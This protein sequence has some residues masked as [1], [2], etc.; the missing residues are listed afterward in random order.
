MN[1]KARKDHLLL[2]KVDDEMVVYD[3]NRKTAHR[4]NGTAVRVWTSLDGHR[5]TSEIADDLDVDESIV[6]LSIDHLAEAHLVE[7]EEPF[8]VSRRQALRRVAIAAAAGFLLPVVTSIAA[9]TA[10]QA[11]SG[12][13]ATP[14]YRRRRRWYRRRRR[15]WRW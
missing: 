15:H 8:S 11:E 13:H 12:G 3:K 4:L 14:T 2:H 5:S 7:S 1:H 9:P 6:T 10:A